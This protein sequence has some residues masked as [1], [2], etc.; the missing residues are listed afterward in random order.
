MLER[1]LPKGLTSSKPAF[2]SLV[3]SAKAS[4]DAESWMNVRLCCGSKS[5]LHLSTLPI[6]ALRSDTKSYPLALQ[7]ALDVPLFANSCSSSKTDHLLR[8]LCLFRLPPQKG[9]QEMMARLNF[10]TG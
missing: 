5:Q 2:L 1:P 4:A 10:V 7:T 3:Q 8:G 6:S 9:Y